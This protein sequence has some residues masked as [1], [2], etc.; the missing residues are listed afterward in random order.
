MHEHFYSV[1]CEEIVTESL[2]VTDMSAVISAVLFRF[3]RKGS[4]FHANQRP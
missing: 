3:E 1:I 4:G 2:T